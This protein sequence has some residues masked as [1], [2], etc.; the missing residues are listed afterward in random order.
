MNGRVY[1]PLL[2]RFGTP[3]P[4][5]ESPFSTQGWNRY[6]Y[7]GNSPTN[8]TDPTGYCFMGCFWKPLFKA[9]GNFFRKAW[10]SILSAAAG[11]ACAPLGLAP[12]CA[13]LVS[14]AVTGIT[15]GNLGLALRA[16]LTTMFTVAA[17]QIVGQE[18]AGIFG[19]KVLGHAAIGCLSAVA[20]GGRCG[21]GALSAAAGAVGTP[22]GP[23]GATVLGG[24][25]SVASGDSFVNGAVT[26]AFGY[27]FNA[28]KG[29]LAGCEA[30]AQQARSLFA[31]WLTGLGPQ[32]QVFG[33]NE[34]MTQDLANE[35]NVERARAA[36]YAKYADKM[37]GG[38]LDGSEYRTN[39]GAPYGVSGF[40]EAEN[41]FG[42]PYSPARAFV[43]SHRIDIFAINGGSELLFELSN[44]T[45]TTSAGHNFG[46]NGDW[47]LSP[48]SRPGPFGTISQK[49]WWTEPVRPLP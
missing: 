47:E 41:P 9:I 4:M 24:L 15:S 28:C 10:G 21:S 18:T 31:Q 32:S 19:A 30:A 14:A 42:S 29:T 1:D 48:V 23:V 3:D 46:F 38:G 7:V 44:D 40:I 13:G 45:S 25:A 8:F 17:F 5:T 35:P 2:G 27:L 37:A 49:F 39:V 34:P 20:S 22:L 12:V 36:F 33:P 11:M 6:S 43:G 26:A 16:G